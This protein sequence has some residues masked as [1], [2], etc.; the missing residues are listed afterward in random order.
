MGWLLTIT[1][2]ERLF[3]RLLLTIPRQEGLFC[4]LAAHYFQAGRTVL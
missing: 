3:R 4:R 2:Q 1:M